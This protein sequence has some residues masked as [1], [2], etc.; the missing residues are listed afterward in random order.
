VAIPLLLILRV[1]IQ[2]LPEVWH[3]PLGTVF[4]LEAS[5]HLSDVPRLNLLA[6]V[7]FPMR[8]LWQAWIR[9]AVPLDTNSVRFRRKTMT[10]STLFQHPTNIGHSDKLKGPQG[11]RP[12]WRA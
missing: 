1:A 11:F 5:S 10:R 9:N 6:A 8:A 7:A 3:K 2:R 4:D 12:Q